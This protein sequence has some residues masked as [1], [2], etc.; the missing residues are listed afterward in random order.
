MS[1]LPPIPPLNDRI[2]GP[3]RADPD[4]DTDQRRRGPE[5]RRSWPSRP[6]RQAPS[7]APTADEVTHCQNHERGERSSERTRGGFIDL[8]IT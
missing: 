3:F 8:L 1:R 4:I 2:L 6:P 7:D 5:E